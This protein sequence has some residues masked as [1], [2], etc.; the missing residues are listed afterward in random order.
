MNESESVVCVCVC[1]CVRFLTIKSIYLRG[2]ELFR[3]FVSS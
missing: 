3:L 1:A 2:I